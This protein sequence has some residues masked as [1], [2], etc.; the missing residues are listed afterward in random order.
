MNT[1]PAWGSYPRR[2]VPDVLADGVAR[3]DYCVAN[4]SHFAVPRYIEFLAD[5]PRTPV[6]RPQKNV[7]RERG[8]TP[9]TWDREEAGYV[10]KL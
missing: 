10:V 9:D 5:L 1:T 3:A 2:S 6:G 4:L 7:L 8:V